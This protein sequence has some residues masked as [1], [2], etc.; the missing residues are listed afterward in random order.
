MSLP[1]LATLYKVG[2]NQ[3]EIRSGAADPSA[4]GGVAA[5]LGSIYLR[6]GATGELW[7]KTGAAAT[8]WEIVDFGSRV[9]AFSYVADG[10]ETA[11]FTVP[12]PAARANATYLVFCSIGDAA[13][14]YAFRLPQTGRTVN[15]FPIT[16][17]SAPEAGDTF[18]FMVCDPS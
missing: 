1:L 3:C 8:A 9:Q 13:A 2:L 16:L 15:D 7:V 5:P 6:E 12:L 18:E 10:S 17:S 14:A 4:G 11:D